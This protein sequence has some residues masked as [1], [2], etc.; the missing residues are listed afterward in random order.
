MLES[1]LRPDWLEQ[2]P[3]YAF[4]IGFTYSL[5]AI[6]SAKI[7][8][9]SSQGIASI[10]FLSLLLVPSLNAILNIEELQDVHSK[11]FSLKRIFKDHSDILEVYMMLFFGI[12]IAYALLSLVYPNLLV[13]GVFDN[14]LKVI[15][16]ATGQASGI[17]LS[18]DSIFWNNL[19]VFFIF[20][21]LS[22]IFGGGSVLFLA[23]NASVWGVVFAYTAVNQANI[24]AAF[25]SI[26]AKILP[27]M[28]TEAAAYF[29]AIVAGG[30]MSVAVLREKAGSVKFSYVVKDGAVFVAVG[31]ALLI[32]GAILEVYLYPVLAG[33]A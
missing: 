10:A 3:R 12:F 7:I 17:I 5:I 1:V 24:W 22:L 8:F 27:H 23:W 15:G 33:I 32:L 9:S 18:F 13:R 31:L 19:K 16:I 14:Q 2:N 28:I 11:K 6:F 20:F 29:F 30:I 25:A 26:L 4:I 21:F